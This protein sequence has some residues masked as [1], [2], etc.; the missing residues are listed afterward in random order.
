MKYLSNFDYFEVN[1]PLWIYPL[2]VY[3][4]LKVI[5]GMSLTI[6]KLIS[7]LWFSNYLFHNWFLILNAIY[8]ILPTKERYVIY[9]NR[10][11]LDPY[12]NEKSSLSQRI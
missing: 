12:D 3:E 2:L 8:L 10:S 5:S 7:I 4:F 9:Y 11:K 6:L 1:L